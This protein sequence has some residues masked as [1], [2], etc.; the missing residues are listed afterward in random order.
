M[1][2]PP[3]IADTH[4]AV[5]RDV[6]AALRPGSLVVLCCG[7][8]GGTLVFRRALADAAWTTVTGRIAFDGLDLPA[9]PAAALRVRQAR[10][11][12]AAETAARAPAP[13]RRSGP[14]RGR[15]R[16]RSDRS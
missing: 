9:R 16:R 8:V 14:T 13:R 1:A 10:L 15:G 4:P 2:T 12:R 6:A 3:T 7:Y 5:A 11:A